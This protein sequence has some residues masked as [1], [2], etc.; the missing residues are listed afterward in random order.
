MFV[1]PLMPVTTV[2]KTASFLFLRTNTPCNSS[3]ASCPAAVVAGAGAGFPLLSVARSARWRMGAYLPQSRRAEH[4]AILGKTGQGKS[5]FLRHLA[6]QDV[7]RGQGFV[8]FD[9]HGDT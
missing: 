1:V 7:Q 9:L 3:L 6:G 8:F 2:T 5:Y 4:L